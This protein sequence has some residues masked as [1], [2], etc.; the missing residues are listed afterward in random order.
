[1]AD[2]IVSLSDFEI[3]FADFIENILGLTQDKVRISYSADGQPFTKINENVCYLKV[4]EEQDDI[5]IYKQR[6]RRYDSETEQLTISQSSMR[7]LSLRV[8]FYGPAC[9]VLAVK[10]KDCFYFESSDE[11]L[12]KNNLSLIPNKTR[13]TSKINEEINSRF[14]ERVDLM[15]YF[16]NSISLSQDIGTIKSANVIIKTDVEVD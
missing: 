6:K 7:V 16:Y 9:D 10:L 4:S 3:K 13:I 11:F 8:V 2:N 1:M 12:Y 14:W 15:L 5:N